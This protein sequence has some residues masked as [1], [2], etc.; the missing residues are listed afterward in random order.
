[1]SCLRFV[2]G[3]LVLTLALTGCAGGAKH[4]N[5]KTFAEGDQ[6]VAAGLAQ[7]EAGNYALAE[8]LL[9]RGV[10]ATKRERGPDAVETASALTSLATV[11]SVQLKFTAADVAIQ[12]AIEI[13]AKTP[14]WLDSKQA[15]F[16]LLTRGTN[17]ERLG[18]CQFARIE[19]EAAEKTFVRL[20]GPESVQVSVAMGARARCLIQQQQ[21][22]EAESLLKHV[23]TI[24]ERA[25]GGSAW[26]VGSAYKDLA[27]CHLAQWRVADAEREIMRALAILEGSLGGEHPRVAEALQTL[28]QMYVVLLPRGPAEAQ[29]VLER[30]LRIQERVFGKQS[31]VVGKTLND[32]VVAQWQMGRWQEVAKTTKAALEISERSL[33]D[34]FDASGGVEGDFRLDYAN[35]L[36]FEQ[37]RIISLIAHLPTP[38]VRRAAAT[39]LLR[40]KGRILELVAQKT[41]VLRSHITAANAGL[42]NGY[43]EK[44]RAIARLRFADAI[45]NGTGEDVPG[46]SQLQAQSNELAVQLLGVASEHS[47]LRRAFRWNEPSPDVSQVIASLPPDSALVEFVNYADFLP[48]PKKFWSS[49]RYG[50]FVIQRSGAVDFV[51]LGDAPPIDELVELLRRDLRSPSLDPKPNARALDELVMRPLRRYLGGA[52][53][54]YIAT[55]SRLSEVPFAALVDDAGDYLLKKWTFS[56]LTSGR[57]LLS[58]SRRA[59]KPRNPAVVFADPAFD[60]ASADTGTD[61][62]TDRAPTIHSLSGVHFSRLPGTLAEARAVSQLLNAQLVQGVA[63]TADAVASVHGPRVLHLATHGFFL[64]DSN[65][66]APAGRGL[67]L[68]AAPGRDLNE[69]DALFRSGLV[70]A[71]ANRPSRPGD[72]LLTAAE[73][74]ALDLDG[75]QLVTLSACQTALGEASAGQGVR[76]LQQALTWAGARALLMSLWNVDDRATAS[77]MVAA[78]RAMSRGQGVA[79]ALREAQLE[80]SG[81]SA[82]AHPYFWSSFIHYGDPSPLTPPI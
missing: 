36:R 41:D 25:L 19:L 48:A 70:L 40:R 76:G 16:T 64:T 78:Y 3:L 68:D 2:G 69:T 18:E 55:D 10:A 65:V 81:S 17:S 43:L 49:V 35:K 21:L 31:P 51:P 15:A 62:A 46:V 9:E 66:P 57:E 27:A 60:G 8:S 4:P 24:R 50:A 54:V 14:G 13:E 79:M 58:A 1:M 53:H 12:S 47:A 34:S 77:L 56:Y 39:T 22:V 80:L 30:A 38:D 5:P 42:L 33:I 6:L 20:F 32:L 29:K 67:V 23:I 73:A 75:T 59:R 82:F 26:A 45:G 44:Q 71:G 11:Y 7:T 28:S 63:A 72:A 61:A 37:D 52:H 74:G